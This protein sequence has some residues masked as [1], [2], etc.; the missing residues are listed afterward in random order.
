MAIVKL[1]RELET[2][3]LARE[4]AR[5]VFEASKSFPREERYALTDQM[6]RSSRAVKAMIS[7]AWGR[8]R[9]R[10]AFINKLDEALEQA[11]ETQSWLDDALDCGYITEKQ[12]HSMDDACQSVGGMLNSMINRAADFCKYAADK[13]YRSL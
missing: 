7:E 9:Y 8:R 13:D 5:T 10:A 2:Y 6:R 4:T 1:F 11:M 12:F 3:K